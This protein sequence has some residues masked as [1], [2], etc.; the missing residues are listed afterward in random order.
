MAVS[1]DE[2]LQGKNAWPVMIS[3]KTGAQTRAYK[4]VMYKNSEQAVVISDKNNDKKFMFLSEET[5][6]DYRQVVHSNETKPSSQVE[7]QLY[8]ADKHQV[9]YFILC[10]DWRLLILS[11]F[12][13]KNRSTDQRTTPTQHR[14]K[15]SKL[16]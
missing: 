8:G 10:C 13:P 9:N 14:R 16:I 7:N 5:N 3:M 4:P 12:R 6:P 15:I 2:W 1:A 11:F